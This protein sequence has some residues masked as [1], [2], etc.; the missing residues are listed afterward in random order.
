MTLDAFVYGRA[1]DNIHVVPS[2]R[3]SIALIVETSCGMVGKLHDDNVVC[4]RH[5]H[6][7]FECIRCDARRTSRLVATCRRLHA[8]GTRVTYRL[9]TKSSLV[10]SQQCDYHMNM[11]MWLDNVSSSWKRVHVMTCDR[12]LRPY[13]FMCP[14]GDST[15]TCRTIVLFVIFEGTCY[16]QIL[17]YSKLENSWPI[18]INQCAG[19]IV[20]YIHYVSFKHS[21]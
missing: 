6:T 1:Y 21:V 4:S 3:L 19:R 17:N 13:R 5:G 8:T 16:I 20:T 9:A 12:T 15:F 2:R 7:T 18:P 14:N 11:T 10:A